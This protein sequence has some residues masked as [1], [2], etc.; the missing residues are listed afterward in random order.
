MEYSNGNIFNNILRDGKKK[1]RVI[2]GVVPSALRTARM[3]LLRTYQS[4]VADIPDIKI[5]EDIDS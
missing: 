1:E 2:C 3:E 4:G 5:K